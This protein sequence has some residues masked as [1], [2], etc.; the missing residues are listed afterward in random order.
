[1][2]DIT[3]ITYPT[4]FIAFI[5][6]LETMMDADE[7]ELNPLIYNFEDGKDNTVMSDSGVEGA[8]QEVLI[9]MNK[10]VSDMVVTKWDVIFNDIAP[11]TI[12]ALHWDIVLNILHFADVTPDTPTNQ[13]LRKLIN[14][15]NPQLLMD[16]LANLVRDMELDNVNKIRDSNGFAIVAYNHPEQ[17]TYVE[18]LITHSFLADKDDNRVEVAFLGYN[19]MGE[20]AILSLID[21]VTS[22][23]VEIAQ[24]SVFSVPG[25][26][27]GEKVLKVKLVKATD[28]FFKNYKAK[29]LDEGV[30]VY[31]M[32]EIAD[33]DAFLDDKVVTLKPL[34]TNDDE[35]VKPIPSIV[36]DQTPYV[37]VPAGRDDIGAWVATVVRLGYLVDWVKLNPPVDLH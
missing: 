28:V 11:D 27:S 18:A 4:S 9:Y 14:D 32:V 37:I 29:F 7:G 25:W 33:N 21:A 1:M 24:G 19:E 31:L 5:R 36:Q 26:A 20:D 23:Q 16:H 34:V 35:V 22:N 30:T 13:H 3:S 6:R 12:M 10:T 15:P 17:N 8:S 2:T